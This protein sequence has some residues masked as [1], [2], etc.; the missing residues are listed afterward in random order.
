M[1]CWQDGLPLID[2]AQAEV[3]VDLRQNYEEVLQVMYRDMR[4]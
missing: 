1:H 3:I 2:K 4:R